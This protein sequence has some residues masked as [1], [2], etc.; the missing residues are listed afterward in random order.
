MPVV[1]SL[2][3]VAP[4]AA[5][6]LVGLILVG[7]TGAVAPARAVAPGAPRPWLRP[8]A[9]PRW[10]AR[11]GRSA[12]WPPTIIPRP[13]FMQPPGRAC[14]RSTDGGGQW[15]ALA[16]SAEGPGAVTALLWAPSTNSGPAVLL[17]GTTTGLWRWLEDEGGW[18]QAGPVAGRGHGG[19]DG[20]GARP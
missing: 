18:S 12:P 7:C 6:L 9:G 5:L 15:A 11:Q 2:A 4:L 1:P 19:G 10:A 13:P 16:G 14:Y 8:W 3:R 17:A 20:A